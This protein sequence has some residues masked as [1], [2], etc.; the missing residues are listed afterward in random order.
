MV[1]ALKTKAKEPMAKKAA[2]T[3]AS[4]KTPGH[5]DGVGAML[6]AH[7]TLKTT[8]AQIEKQFGEGAIMPL[9]AGVVG[10]IAGVSTGSLSL[11]M[12]L[13]GQGIPSGRVVEIFGPESSGKT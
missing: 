7:P 2:P 10:R 4:A 3:K 11:D 9:G 6:D 12:A 5:N 13:G 8:V 1:T